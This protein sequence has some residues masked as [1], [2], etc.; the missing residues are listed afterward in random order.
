MIKAGWIMTVL[1]TLFMLGASV[2]P[3]FLQMDAAVQSLI[4]LGW[5]PDYLLMIGGIELL[6]TLL[7]L[8]PR[9]ALLGAIVMTGLLGGSLASN[10]RAD[11]PMFS[12]T[13]FS[14]YLGV[15]MWAALWL[16][17]EKLRKLFPIQTTH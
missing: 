13:L 15:F 2:T 7:F 5:S 10:L 11:M 12:F 1:F 6:C 4:T 17:D 14:I 3:K 9:T 8:I 16:R